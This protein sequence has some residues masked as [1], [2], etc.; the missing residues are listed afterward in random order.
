MAL[1]STLVDNFEDNSFDTG[2]WSR[3]NSSNMLEQ[4]NRFEMSAV[5][6]TRTFISVNTYDLT[7][8]S[9]VWKVPSFTCVLSPP[10]CG[11]KIETGNTQTNVIFFDFS[12]LNN[13]RLSKIVAG[14]TTFGTTLQAYSSSTLWF[15]IRESG[16][17]VYGDY[18]ADSLTWTNLDSFAT[19]I[20][21]TALRYFAGTSSFISDANGIFID[22]VNTPTQEATSPFT[23]NSNSFYNPS[24][25]YTQIL[26]LS[27]LANNSLVHA[28]G[29][30][31]PGEYTTYSSTTK[32]T[33]S[34]NG[35]SKIS[36]GYRYPEQ[37]DPV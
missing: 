9:I 35:Q 25:Q 7:S 22:S 1:I 4:N 36:T 31:I 10:R 14:T 27:L 32:N 8:S 29:S 20:T 17:T 16:G 11:V 18:S 2:L 28:P 13:F 19:P 33:T 26:N 3:T 12:S 37:G 34:F 23:T 15:R 24:A 30:Y 6:G 21:I 5:S